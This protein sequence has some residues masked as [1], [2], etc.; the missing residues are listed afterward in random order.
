MKGCRNTEV[1][2]I[3]GE[4]RYLV[5]EVLPCRVS[6]HYSGEKELGSTWYGWEMAVV[7]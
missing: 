7:W 5:V 3:L 1:E 2:L 6:L 4:L